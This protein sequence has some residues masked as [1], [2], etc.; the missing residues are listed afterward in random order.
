MYSLCL[1]IYVIYKLILFNKN[2]DCQCFYH[3]PSPLFT[4]NISLCSQKRALEVPHLIIL[5]CFKQYSKTPVWAHYMRVTG[6]RKKCIIVI[7]P[8]WPINQWVKVVAHAFLVNINWSRT[9]AFCCQ[10]NL[11]FEAIILIQHICLLTK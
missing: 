3:H 2:Y 11:T 1:W 7:A 9:T 5:I 4:Q 6:G 8:R 10:L